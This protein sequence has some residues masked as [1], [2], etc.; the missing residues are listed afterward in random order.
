[1]RGG[2]LLAW[3]GAAGPLLLRLLVLA[4]AV[5]AAQRLADG[6]HELVWQPRGAIDLGLRHKEV[7]LWFSGQ[8]LSLAVYPPA[9]YTILWP[10]VGWLPF[11]AARWLWAAATAAALAWLAW[12]F[13]RESGAETRG[14]RLVVALLP[15]AM[16]PTRA[17]IVNGQILLHLLPALLTGLLLLD[18]SR[19]RWGRDLA[20][21]GLVLFALVKLTVAVPFLWALIFARRGW[22]PTLIV[23]LAYLGL[24]VLAV[25]FQPAGPVALFHQWVT[26]AVRDAARAAGGAHANLHS[27]LTSV[28]LETLDAPASLLALAALGWWMYRC[29]RE[30]P[31]LRL[32]VAAL[33]ARFWTF[34]YRYDDVLIVVPMIALFRLAKNRSPRGAPDVTAGVLLAVTLATVL[35]PARLLFAPWPW[36]ALFEAGQTAAWLGVLAFLARRGWRAR[37]APAAGARPA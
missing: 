23:G 37:L 12:L 6:F 4:M 8:P 31:W 24:T 30:D 15:L 1:M 21:G 29:R 22:R 32:G 19:P 27:W 14:E 36:S 3:W 34:H 7:R 11:T 2:R 33:V 20:A 26:D 35:A 9:S 10:L 16:Y 13:V 5:A 25:A 28:G 18:R 17:V